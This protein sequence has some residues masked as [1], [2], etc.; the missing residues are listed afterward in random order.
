VHFSLLL[1]ENRSTVRD[2][3]KRNLFCK[4]CPPHTVDYE[5]DGGMEGSTTSGYERSEMNTTSWQ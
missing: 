2:K 5:K 4:V 1:V 3:G